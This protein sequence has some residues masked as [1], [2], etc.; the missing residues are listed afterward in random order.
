M[1]IHDEP[2][3]WHGRLAGVFRLEWAGG[4]CHYWSDG[5]AVERVPTNSKG[6]IQG[7]ES[8]AALAKSPH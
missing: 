6:S 4:P 5:D 3:E 8:E 1:E 7:S 2:R